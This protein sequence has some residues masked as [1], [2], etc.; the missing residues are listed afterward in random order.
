M[1]QNE[2]LNIK[3]D[4]TDQEF[5]LQECRILNLRIRIKI[6][7]KILDARPDL[8]LESSQATTQRAKRL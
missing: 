8:F 2:V 1:I 3:E 4:L 5:F 6:I 7:S